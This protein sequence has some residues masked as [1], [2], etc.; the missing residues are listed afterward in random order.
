MT[1]NIVLK[2]AFDGSSFH[3]WQRQG[4]GLA[5]VQQVL[6]EALSEI[7]EGKVTLTG[8]SRTDAGVHA[9]E[10]FCN[11]KTASRIPCDRLP[12]AINTKTPL[13]LSVFEAKEAPPGFSARF[14]SKGKEYLY[15]IYTGRHKH[16]FLAGRAWHYPIAL[17]VASMQ[18]AAEYM[19]GKRDFSAFMATGSL[20]ASPVRN[21]SGLSVEKEGEMISIRTYADGYLYNMVR[22]LCGTLVYAGN[23]KLAPEDIPAIL[24]SRDRTK[25]GPTAPPDGLYLN[26][27]D[28]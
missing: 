24:E 15:K 27:V 23:G 26:R 5:T 18:R 4:G 6:E 19:V 8:C 7:T 13:S 20:V 1:R 9:N 14:S 17:S 10:F 3:G 2:L 21:L 11:F 25:A 22:I 12:F 28:Y 16:P